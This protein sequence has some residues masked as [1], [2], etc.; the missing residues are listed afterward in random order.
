M[1]EVG[2]LEASKRNINNVDFILS[3]AENYCSSEQYDVIFISGLMIYLNDEQTE[4]LL[5]N[6]RAY[7]K[8]ES[9]ILLRDGTGSV[10]DSKSITATL[11]ICKQSIRL[12]IELLS[13]TKLYLRGMVSA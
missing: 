13:N 9:T 12:H 8:P 5:G 2:K 10:K 7:S 3:S 4:K 1:I 6:L 11:R